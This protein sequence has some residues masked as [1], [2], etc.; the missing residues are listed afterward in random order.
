MREIITNCI[1]ERC[2]ERKQIKPRKI[3]MM[4][5]KGK[6]PIGWTKPLGDTLCEECSKEFSTCIIDFMV[7]GGKQ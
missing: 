6:Y 3:G 4:Y 2:H 5:F 1:C 7:I